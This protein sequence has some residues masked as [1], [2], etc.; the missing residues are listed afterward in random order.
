MEVDR[1]QGKEGQAARAE[2][3][4]RGAAGS[5]GGG[6]GRRRLGLVGWE[7]GPAFYLSTA[8]RQ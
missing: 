1:P 7:E 4:G 6:Q 8:G 5:M 2:V 3:P